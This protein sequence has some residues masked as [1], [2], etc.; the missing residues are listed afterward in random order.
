MNSS[1]SRKLQFTLFAL[2]SCYAVFLCFSV[3]RIAFSINSLFFF[4]LAPLLVK[5]MTYYKNTLVQFL[6]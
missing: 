6:Y 4:L 3:F 5:E 1:T 2:F